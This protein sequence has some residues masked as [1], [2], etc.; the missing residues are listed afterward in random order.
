MNKEDFTFAIPRD[1]HSG[2][3][4]VMGKPNVGKSTLI[5]KI[6]GHKVSIVSSKPQTTRHRIL[7]VKSGE[8][9]QVVFVDTPGVH[10]PEHVLGKYMEKTYKNELID[11]DMAILIIEGT[12]EPTPDDY[13][14]RDTITSR[15]E[16]TTPRLL[17]VNKIDVSLPERLEKVRELTAS[18]EGFNDTF[19][20]SALKGTGID[21]LEK[22]ILNLLPPGPPYFPDDMKTDQNLEFQAAE[23]VR[24]KILMNTRQEVPHSVFV[25]TD[26]V[27][28]GETEGVTYYKVMI[29]VERKSQKGIIIGKN[30]RMLKKVGSLAR[31]ELELI[32][33]GKVFLD[34]WV[35]VKE[36]WKD[37][38]DLLKSWG[39]VV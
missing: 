15:M 20:I 12:H 29:Y 19:E 23:V 30:G 32:T 24:E 11:A 14:A 2:F 28:E 5:N 18:W 9:H 22:R 37:R 25:H 8:K 1:Y 33:G 6:V 13:R 27:R 10:K 7:G 38:K 3:V 16:K 4:T 26:E 36:D 34:L 35:K 39:Y 21:K 17:V 31:E